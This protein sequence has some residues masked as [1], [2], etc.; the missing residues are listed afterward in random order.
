MVQLPHCKVRRVVEKVVP[1]FPAGTVQISVGGSV[2]VRVGA[3]LG[4]EICQSLFGLE[5]GPLGMGL[6]ELSRQQQP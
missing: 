1:V 3:L 6:L 5:W 4:P 2:W